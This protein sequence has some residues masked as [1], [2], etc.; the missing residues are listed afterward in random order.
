MLRKEWLTD[1]R[2][3]SYRSKRQL[4]IEWIHP[5]ACTSSLYMLSMYRNPARENA[6]RINHALVSG[7]FGV[8]Q[9]LCLWLSGF[10]GAV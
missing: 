8:F 5:G 10:L 7:S 9:Y 4:K 3:E 6:L 1:P 2:A